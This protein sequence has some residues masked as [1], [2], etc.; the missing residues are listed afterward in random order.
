MALFSSFEIEVTPLGNNQCRVTTRGQSRTMSESALLAM[1]GNY[2]LTNKSGE[3][4]LADDVINALNS[5][6]GP[7]WVSLVERTA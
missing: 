5:C 2:A 1:L 6:N 3:P 7:V 4:M